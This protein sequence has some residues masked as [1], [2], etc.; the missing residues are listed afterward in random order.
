[1]PTV[2]EQV[3]DASVLEGF[4][5]GILVLGLEYATGHGGCSSVRLGVPNCRICNLTYAW[6][7]VIHVYQSVFVH[8]EQAD[9]EVE[10]GS[11]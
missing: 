2:L 7:K 11:C 3:F 5:R 1:M 6:S 10:T 4:Y 8:S 9:T